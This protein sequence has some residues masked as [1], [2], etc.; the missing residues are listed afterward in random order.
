MRECL[1]RN[2]V[3]FLGGAFLAA[4]AATSARADDGFDIVTLSSRPDTVSGGD[5]LVKIVGDARDEVELL[6]SQDLLH[7][8]ADIVE[9]NRRNDHQ[10]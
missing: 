5:V 10:R 9:L 7:F 1:F 3:V 6:V 2:L 4:T 8:C